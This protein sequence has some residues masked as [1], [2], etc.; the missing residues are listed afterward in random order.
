[1]PG[2]INNEPQT[3]EVVKNTKVIFNRTVVLKELGK[4]LLKQTGFVVVV[5]FIFKSF[6][7][8]TA[9]LSI[10]FAF[11]GAGLNF[12][13]PKN[14]E[15]LLKLSYIEVIVLIIGIVTYVLCQD[16]VSNSLSTPEQR[17][18]SLLLVLLGYALA[19][20]IS[21]GLSFSVEAFQMMRNNSLPDVDVAEYSFGNTNNIELSSQFEQRTLI[22]NKISGLSY[23]VPSDWH[24]VSKIESQSKVTA[25]GSY[26]VTK[27]SNGDDL[28]ITTG[29]VYPFPGKAFYEKILS[30]DEIPVKEYCPF[31]ILRYNQC[32]T[33][34][35]KNGGVFS[36][37]DIALGNGQYGT[38]LARYSP[39]AKQ[40]TVLRKT[41]NDENFERTGWN[42]ID[43]VSVAGLNTIAMPT[44]VTQQIAEPKLAMTIPNFWGNPFVT[45]TENGTYEISFTAF[46]KG[47]LTFTV[48]PDD[49][50]SAAEKTRLQ[51][52]YNSNNSI[53]TGWRWIGKDIGNT[54]INA[55]VKEAP[56]LYLQ[57][58][59]LSQH[60]SNQLFFIQAQKVL[61]DIIVSTSPE[62]DPVTATSTSASAINYV[63]S[64]PG[65]KFTVPAGLNKV[66]ST[67]IIEFTAKQPT[68]QY[69]QSTTS[70]V[71]SECGETNAP[72]NC[73]DNSALT[74]GAMLVVFPPIRTAYQQL[75]QLQGNL[76]K[77]TYLTCSLI[78]I[79]PGI[80]AL[81]IDY[82][83]RNTKEIT[84]FEGGT[85]YSVRLRFSLDFTQ[86]QINQIMSVFLKSASI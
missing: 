82:T 18:P 5:N 27:F 42:I 30:Y 2:T 35:L 21:L 49:S 45:R 10:L 63:T 3:I 39:S 66:L 40:F 74:S 76:C 25:T 62:S 13:I 84:V 83:G 51:Q 60:E 23:M 32:G 59:H 57:K 29:D 80:E 77:G 44:L 20:G 48:M 64:I 75:S 47:Y 34:D 72:K 36:F 33:K 12:T 70:L 28:I 53:A 4:F 43:T 15:F 52:M 17:K 56:K 22:T 37:Q 9:F 38:F 55:L 24:D 7:F 50:V 79:K 11:G 65:L 85:T 69:Q 86:E 54:T 14:A 19:V 1:M 81:V 8:G 67:K 68:E 16:R 41:G 6:V 71:H 78:T 26:F 58:Y 31:P 61:A 46:D 73:I